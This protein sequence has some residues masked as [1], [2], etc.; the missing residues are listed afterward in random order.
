MK[1]AEAEATFREFNSARSLEPDLGVDDLAATSGVKKKK[2]DV[3]ET[4]YFSVSERGSLQ[5]KYYTI[6]RGLLKGLIHDSTSIDIER[7]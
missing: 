2:V 7:S 3:L 5:R 4:E 6:I 1:E